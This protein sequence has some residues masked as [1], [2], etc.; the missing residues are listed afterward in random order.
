M[1]RMPRVTGTHVV[2]S[3]RKVG[4]ELV[5]QRGSHAILKHP[6]GRSTV[7]PIHGGETIGVGLMSKIQRDVGIDR[8]AFI[9]LLAG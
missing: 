7:V 2:R 6:D 9:D 5:R 3:L 8:E 1:N 4:F